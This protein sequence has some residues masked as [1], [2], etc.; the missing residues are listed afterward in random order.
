MGDE[1][2]NREDLENPDLFK[3]VNYWLCA[4]NSVCFAVI[5]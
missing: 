5:L 4:D 1:P 2:E 3:D